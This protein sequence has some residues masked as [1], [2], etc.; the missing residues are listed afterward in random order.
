M[1][2]DKGASSTDSE[3]AKF[4]NAS[5][6]VVNNRNYGETLLRQEIPYPIS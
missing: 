1:E 2:E 6:S 5:T 3:A 4:T